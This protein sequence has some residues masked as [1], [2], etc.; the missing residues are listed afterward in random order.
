MFVSNWSKADLHWYARQFEVRLARY[1]S[2]AAQ[3]VND[4]MADGIALAR[5]GYGAIPASAMY[6]VQPSVPAAELFGALDEIHSIAGERL[7]YVHS[8]PYSLS[9][10]VY[11]LADV[12]PQPLP[13]LYSMVRSE[14]DRARFVERF[15]GIAGQ[16][17]YI[18]T[19]DRKIPELDSF[20]AAHPDATYLSR[21]LSDRP[22]F[23]YGVFQTVAVP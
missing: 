17:D 19:T 12:V 10:L 8:F 16:V 20:L 6:S 1:F 4:G 15:E 9:G 14:E 7:V 5:S 2:P 18:V 11:F 22:Y 21:A 3:T 23:I 13:D